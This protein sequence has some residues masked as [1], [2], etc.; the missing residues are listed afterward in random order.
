MFLE[1]K[2]TQNS[3]YIYITVLILSGS[4]IF[5]Q[6]ETKDSISSGIYAYDRGYNI[7]TTTAFTIPKGTLIYQNFLF[8]VNNFEYGLSDNAS[9]GSGFSLFGTLHTTIKLKLFQK[10]KLT[11]SLFNL[12]L[13]FPK[14][15]NAFIPIVYLNGAKSI[16][17]TD[18]F[19]FG[20]G[21]FHV[22]K[23]SSI[24]TVGY[25]KRFSKSWAFMFDL[26]LPNIN[27]VFSKQEE[28]NK[29]FF[30]PIP[31]IGVRYFSKSGATFD[32][33]Y[34]FLAMKYPLIKATPRMKNTLF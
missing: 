25:H 3:V 14:A 17:E 1:K 15:N 29:Y 28:R 24:F 23:P 11:V 2:Y 32:L 18:Y 13:F 19:S 9:I 12:N 4:S 6:P 31:M 22:E 33:G 27:F 20:T 16:N 21:L 8:V 30:F 34:S 10:K 5:G 7:I 26:W